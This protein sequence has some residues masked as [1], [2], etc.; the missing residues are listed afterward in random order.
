VG[1]G[2]FTPDLSKAAAQLERRVRHDDLDGG[3]LLAGRDGTW[4]GTSVGI[5][6]RT[7]MPIASA[8]KWLTAAVVMSLVDEGRLTLDTPVVD[9]LPGF[10]GDTA[11]VTVRH[12]L[13]HTSGLTADACVSS[14]SG[15]T[16]ACTERLAAGP[17][18]SGR[19][20]RRFVY[21][22]VG[23]E[24]AGRIV[25]VLTGRSFEAAFEDRIAR[26]L[27]MERTAFDVTVGGDRVDHPVPSASATST[28]D[29]YMRFLAMLA[30]DGVARTGP[31]AGRRVLTAASVAAI[32]D[33]QVRGVD[34]SADPAVQTTGIPTYGLG[35]WRDVVSPDDA[36]RVV[37]G[38]GA[39]GFYPWID[40][41]PASA[42]N[43]GVVAVAD[44]VHGSGYA[45]PRSQKNA[46]TAW[47]EA[48][49]VFG[50]PTPTATAG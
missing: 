20:G 42:G 28:A 40:R 45:V 30:S 43:F 13:S 34:T 2:E 29:D 19:P 22:G 15:T 11:A 38:N 14:G 9:V 26:P 12:L 44:L 50:P 37:S 24:V 39:F 6:A 27:G 18:P 7:V 21:S 1:A 48:A 16:A 10:G 46:R 33:D 5:T 49:R 47:N 8:S 32:E 17:A 3:V 4:S 31:A 41:R 23:Y 35:V 36:I 25:E